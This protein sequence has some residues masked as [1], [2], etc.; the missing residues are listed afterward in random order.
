MNILP[1]NYGEFMKKS[2]WTKFFNKLKNSEE[3]FF[4]WYGNYKEFEYIL[5]SVMDTSHNILN[6][7][8]GNSL[9]SEDL[10]DDGF[11]NILNVD[12]E[13]NVI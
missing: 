7:G 5:R 12:Y 2:Y 13:E 1:K 9:F 6:I 8:C 10:Y 4:E 11:T 3:E